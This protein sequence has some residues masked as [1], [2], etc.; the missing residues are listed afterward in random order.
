MK[1]ID[2]DTQ[3][4]DNNGLKINSP[5]NIKL[6]NKDDPDNVL[7]EKNTQISTSKE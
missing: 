1:L 2:K 4:D 3:L 7:S 5:E 6:I